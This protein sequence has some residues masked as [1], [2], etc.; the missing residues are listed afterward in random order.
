LFSYEKHPRKTRKD[1]NIVRLPPPFLAI[2]QSKFIF[3]GEVKN[4]SP[5]RI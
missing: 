1:R 3:R 4:H 5:R 2:N